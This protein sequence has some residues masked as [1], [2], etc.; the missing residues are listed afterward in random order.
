[1]KKKEVAR[2]KVAHGKGLSRKNSYPKAVRFA[3]G[4]LKLIAE[5]VKIWEYNFPDENHTVNSFIRMSAVG[6]AK[7][8]INAATGT[9]KFKPGKKFKK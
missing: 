7:R 6:N 1:M 8:T 9:L 3:D 2:Q 5:A 4:E